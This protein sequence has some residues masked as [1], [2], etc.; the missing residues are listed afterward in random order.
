MVP[1]PTY[2]VFAAEQCTMRVVQR[3]RRL[4]K[5]SPCN[6]THKTR[7]LEVRGHLFLLLSDMGRGRA[8]V[9]VMKTNSQLCHGTSLRHGVT[10]VGAHPKFSA[11]E[12]LLLAEDY[13]Q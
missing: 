8:N 5:G 2:A 6:D 7:S 9:M 1:S 11:V 3:R 12:E 10:A 4:R 13:Y